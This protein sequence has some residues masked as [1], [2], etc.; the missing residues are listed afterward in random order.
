MVPYWAMRGA[1]ETESAGIDPEKKI[2]LRAESTFCKMKG[3]H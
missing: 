1:H 3:I 2:N